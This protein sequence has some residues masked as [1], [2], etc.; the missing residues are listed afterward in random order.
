MPELSYVPAPMPLDEFALPEGEPQG[1][2]DIRDALVIREGPTFLLTDPDGNVSAGNRF[3][4][5]IYHADTRHL[6]AYRLTLNGVR[7][8][9]LLSTAEL[10]YA[11]EQVMT[12][13]KLTLDG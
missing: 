1:I 10:G 12:N 8:V 2:E 6:S 3:G 9:M 4:Y 11:M 13:P 5:G 7:P